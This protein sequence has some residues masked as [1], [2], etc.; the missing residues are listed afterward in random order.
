MRPALNID[1][2]SNAAILVNYNISKITVIPY[3]DPWNSLRKIVCNFFNGL[4]KIITHQ[5]TTYNITSHTNAAADTYYAVRERGC[6]YDTT[7][8]HDGLQHSSAADLG[9]RKHTCP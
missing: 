7:F 1:I 2:V 8:C 3:T 9:W 6:M 4:I 5:V